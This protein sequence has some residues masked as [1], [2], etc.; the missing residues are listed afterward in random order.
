M[1]VRAEESAAGDA[2]TKSSESSVRRFLATASR[3]EIVYRAVRMAS[4]IGTVLAL[5]N[6]GPALVSGTMESQRWFQVGLTYFVPY[7]VATYAAVMQELRHGLV[8]P[9]LVNG[10]SRS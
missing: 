6:H 10:Q 1:T 8:K 4:L 9:R 2:L 7:G 5:I 3:R